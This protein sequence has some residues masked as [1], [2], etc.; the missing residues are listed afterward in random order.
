[1][2]G[3]DSI[4]LWSKLSMC[5][6]F[7]WAGLLKQGQTGGIVP[8]Q[9]FLVSKMIAPVPPTYRGRVIE[10]GAGTGALTARL[11]ARCRG[12]RIL[13]IEL[14]PTL[15]RVNREHLAKTGVSGRVEVLTGR[16]EDLLPQVA[17]HGA[18]KADYVVSGI[19]LAILEREKV[20]AL[21]DTIWNALTDGGLYIQFQHSLL[22]RDTIRSRF[23]RL[24]TVP[25][26]LNFPPAVVY[27]AHRGG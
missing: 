7:A 1:M 6:H 9:R 2:T 25:V 3:Q 20:R 24:H 15:A 4:R 16:A 27:Y 14:N 12:A 18:D 8:S 13:A 5:M 11:A 26:W 23:P 17:G 19:P 21:V 22:S 10:L